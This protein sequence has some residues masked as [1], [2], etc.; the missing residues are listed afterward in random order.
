MI[1]YP[2][3]CEIITRT[4][5]V[6]DDLKQ[7]CR[8]AS[9]ITPKSGNANGIQMVFEV[10]G[11]LVLGKMEIDAN[12][13]RWVTRNLSEQKLNGHCLKPP[14]VS[15]DVKPEDGEWDEESSTTKA[16][17][18]PPSSPNPSP[19]KCFDTVSDDQE[20]IRAVKDMQMAP[21]HAT[22]CACS[23]TPPEDASE[24]TP[25]EP[26]SPTPGLAFPANQPLAQ[27]TEYVQ[28][29]LDILKSLS[30]QQ[31]PPPL[32]AKPSGESGEPKARASRLEFKTV[33]EVYVS[34]AART[35]VC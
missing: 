7:I 13:Y 25:T 35:K 33:N 19:S 34:N 9:I 21:G 1:W 16:P 22:K 12:V 20:L 24:A 27:V 32:P 14:V 18:A 3:Y 4:E 17:T 15:E 2:T 30:P 31:G 10:E 23:H 8:S 28:Q 6:F 29:V 11:M 26:C 5:T